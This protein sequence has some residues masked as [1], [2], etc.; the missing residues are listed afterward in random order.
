MA[1]A[2]KA[3]S[4][5]AVETPLKQTTAKA[6]WTGFLSAFGLMSIPVKSYKATDTDEIERHTYHSATCLNRMKQN[7]KMV[8]SGCNAEVDKASPVK[9]VE[10]NGKIV[11]VTDDEINAQKPQSEKKLEVFEFVPAESIDVTYYE[12][13]EYLAAGDGG[14]TPFATFREALALSGRVAIGRVVSRGH[15]YYVAIR[16]FGQHGLVM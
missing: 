9:G 7:G 12:S 10:V 4:N 13:S 5:P 1:K 14:S 6:V 16:P 8:C 3:E 2:K 15:E 11:I